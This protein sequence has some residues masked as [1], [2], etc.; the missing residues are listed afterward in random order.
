MRSMAAAECSAGMEVRRS[1]LLM[2]T[3]SRKLHDPLAH[4]GSSRPL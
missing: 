3:A 2:I 1:T 4:S